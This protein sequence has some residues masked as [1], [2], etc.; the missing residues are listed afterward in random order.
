[1]QHKLESTRRN[2]E[3]MLQVMSGMKRQIK[4]L[5]ARE[6]STIA[7]VRKS[8]QKME[9]ALLARDQARTL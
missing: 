6:D 8:K 5:S 1:M 2:A 3:G 4:E 9:D 7:A